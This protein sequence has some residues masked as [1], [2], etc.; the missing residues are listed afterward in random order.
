MPDPL[1][2]LR[3]V[4]L[5]GGATRLRDVSVRIDAGVTAVMGPS[6]A[7][8]T[9]LLNL[10]VGF[11]QPDAG[12]VAC[13]LAAGAAG[14]P[15]Y[16]VPQGRGLWPRQR[17]IDHLRLVS[18]RP[19]GDET[20]KAL[21]A[22]LEDVDLA[23]RAEAPPEELSE[24]ERARLA[25]ARGLAAEPRVLVMDEP[26]SGVDEVGK[27]AYWEVVR[28]HLK[29]IGASLLFA[30]HHEKPVLAEARDVICLRDGGVVYTGSVSNLYH[31]PAT[32]E[33]AA[34]LGEANWL[35]P[36]ESR[37][38]LG[39]EE[40]EA[41]CYRPEQIVVE[42]SEP[43]TAVVQAARFKGSV[44]EADVVHAE[45]GARRTFFHR[46][47]GDTLREGARVVVKA[48][49]LV[50]LF[51]AAG[52]D[53]GADPT[54][55]VTEVRTWQM[56][57]EGPR[58]PK[59]RAVAL[60]EAGTAYVLDTVGRIVVFDQRGDMLRTWHMPAHDIGRPEGILVL[61]DG[62]LAVAD[63]HYAR[64]VF[65]STDG[66]LLGMFGEKGDEPGRF[67][68]PVS[69]AQDDAGH[70]YVGEYGGNDRVQKFTLDGTFLGAFGSFG[71]Q[72][73]QFQRAAGIAWR[74]GRVYV[75]DAIN[76]RIQVFGDDGAYIG[77]IGP[78]NGVALDMPYDVVPGPDDTLYV[79]EYRGGRLTQVQAEP[80]HPDP[81]VGRFGSTGWEMEQFHTPWGL[82]ADA[83]GRILIADTRNARMVELI[84]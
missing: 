62:R 15:C 41:R 43:A 22:L 60:G 27:A 84:R 4:S 55:D 61:Q 25:V 67:R 18:P 24:G 32:P 66:E 19:P 11:E 35:A 51:L 6:G 71:E 39:R 78:G 49:C 3:D 1:W 53:G 69:L 45:T 81:V 5:T 12:R 10:L 31:R 48:L 28:D 83:A 40:A 38:W 42:P 20:D 59:P 2:T 75:A 37:A 58:V 30:T 64:I 50:L 54:L 73:T 34:C 29:R 80:G 56:P 33:L 72:R 9:S 82:T 46:P 8:K 74:N 23:H 79:I 17:A 63:T 70:L 21:A 36:E 77:E 7:G 57:A 52:C 68:Y 26:L 44:A 47:C 13:H 16:W 14:L 65:F 76:N